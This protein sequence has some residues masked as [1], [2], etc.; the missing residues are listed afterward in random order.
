[1]TDMKF[2]PLTLG[3]P[4]SRL[5]RND[6]DRRPNQVV[7]SARDY[8]EWRETIDKPREVIDEIPAARVLGKLRRMRTASTVRPWVVLGERGSGKSRL[9]AHWHEI[10]ARH[11]A[12]L[13]LTLTSFG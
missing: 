8:D 6:P 2:I 12:V 4:R 5:A 9:F 1:M 13:P 11:S 10:L 3:M 7:V